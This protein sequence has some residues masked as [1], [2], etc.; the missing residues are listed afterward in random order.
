MVVGGIE[1]DR[2]MGKRDDGQGNQKGGELKRRLKGVRK[3]KQVHEHLSQD[4]L[5]FKVRLV[6][7][8]GRIGR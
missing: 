5:A 8:R 1:G 7:A 6:E 4:G 3:R 2:V